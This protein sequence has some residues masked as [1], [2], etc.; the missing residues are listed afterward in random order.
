MK[1]GES[2][3]GNTQHRTV[4]L[5]Q[6]DATI[7]SVRYGLGRWIGVDCVIRRQR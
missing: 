5:T 4:S 6:L 2:H 3:N 1:G 7:R